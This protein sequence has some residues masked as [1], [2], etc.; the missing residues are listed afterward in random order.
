M[1]EDGTWYD[2]SDWAEG[3]FEDDGVEAGSR[4]GPGRHRTTRAR[5]DDQGADYA[6][7][8]RQGRRD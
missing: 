1:S 3:S 5:S 8:T 4:Q 6:S 7:M 2:E